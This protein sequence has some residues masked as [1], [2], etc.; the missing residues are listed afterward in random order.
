MTIPTN[1]LLDDREQR[2]TDWGDSVQPVIYAGATLYKFPRPV[3]RFRFSDA[4]D[5][6]RFKVPLKDGESHVGHSRNGVRIV[7]EGQIAAQDGDAKQ[8]EAEMFAEIETMRSHLNAN[9]TNGKFE[10]FLFHD[11]ATPF[12]RKFKDCSTIR[13]DLDLSTKTLFTYAVEIHSDDPTVY[14]TAEGQ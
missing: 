5:F 10:L 2:I 6:D 14:A 9:A 3:G 11:P 1:M 12:Y 7:I 13:F 4:W 8:T